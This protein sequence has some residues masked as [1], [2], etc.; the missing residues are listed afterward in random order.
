M[1]TQCSN[2]ATLFQVSAR[3]LRQAQGLARCCLCD[4]VFDATASLLETLPAGL[5]AYAPDSG[6]E[7][8]PESDASSFLPGEDYFTTLPSVDAPAADELALPAKPSRAGLG[9]IGISGVFL[10][11][12][13]AAV[14]QYAYVMRMELAQYPRLRPWIESLCLAAGCQVPL[15]Q[16]VARI[17]VLHK[18]A[19]VRPELPEQLLVQAMIAND[20]AFWQP[21]PHIRLRFLDSTGS[22]QTSRWFAPDDY[23]PAK[24]AYDVQAGMPPQEPVLI[25][26]KAANVGVTAQDNFMMDLR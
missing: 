19:S 9:I 3:H 22:V 2:C 10:L 5:E 11:L 6:G 1:Y 21:Y 14:V 17:Q 4:E 23:L 16:D 8:Q 20:A 25:R 7:I 13:C 18:D 26:L 12:L 24:H 15:L